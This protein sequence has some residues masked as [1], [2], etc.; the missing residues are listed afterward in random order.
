MMAGSASAA[1]GDTST[2]TVV[3]NV[4]VNSSIAL[5][6][7][8][9]EFTLNGL[10]GAL[11]IGAQDVSFNVVTNNIGGYMVTVQAAAPTLVPTAVGN[12]DSIPIGLLRVR[13]SVSGNTGSWTSMSSGSTVTVHNQGTRSDPAGDMVRNDY[14]IQIPFVAEDTYHATLNYIA[15]TL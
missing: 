15:T 13:E 10:P 7:L 5:N 12:P 4:G 8:T 3:A 2:D 14:Q 9:P 1:P 11:V 6:G